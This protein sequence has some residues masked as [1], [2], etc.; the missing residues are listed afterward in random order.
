MNLN[1]LKAFLRIVEKG[2]F[3]AAARSLGIS[4][5]AVSLQMQ[6]LEEQVGVELLDRRSKKV[7]LTE[8][9]RLFLETAT[10][11]VSQFDD[12]QHRIDDIGGSVRGSIAVGGSTIPGEY[13]LPR[14]LGKFKKEFPEVSI[15]LRVADTNEIVEQLIA[16]DLHAGV[17]G[18]EPASRRLVVRPFVQDELVM[19]VPAGHDLINRD[20][21]KIDELS[22]A[23]FVLRE[24]G[25]GTRQAIEK[26]LAKLGLTVHDLKAV[27]E[28]GSTEAVVNAVS[29]G[30]GVSIVSI[31]AVERYL[32]LGELETVKL[33]DSPVLRNFY[34]VESKQSSS[35]SVRAFIEFVT[36]TD[37]S[38][39][40]LQKR[41]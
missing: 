40:F 11:I 38:E 28:L 32:K 26:Y 1:Q 13:I 27:M 25:S 21:V 33:P 24:R 9:G 31:W 22:N 23:D 30:L 39:I 8:A 37:L 14:L 15:S 12:F 7:Q 17:V 16:G 6:A 18:A 4:Q 19:I 41:A 3:S 35:R 34:L 36:N 10:M 29:A 5:P 20:V 2:T